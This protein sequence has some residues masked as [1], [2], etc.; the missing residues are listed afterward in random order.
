MGGV[1]DVSAI[2]TDAV[3]PICCKRD[4]SENSLIFRV[5]VPSVVR[6]FA[7]VCEKDQVPFDVIVPDPVREPAEKSDVLIP[8]PYSE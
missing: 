2:V 6:S 5:S 7:I 4:E 3:D 1:V 8:V